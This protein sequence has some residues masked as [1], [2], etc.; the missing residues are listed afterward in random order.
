MREHAKA[1]L[2]PVAILRLFKEGKVQKEDGFIVCAP[3]N[4]HERSVMQVSQHSRNPRQSNS[5]KRA[6]NLT[7]SSD[8]LD[9]AKRL[10][11]NLSKVCD[12]YLREFVRREQERKWRLDHAEF[13][14]AYNASISAEGLPLDQWRGF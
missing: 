2:G 12:D 1:P 10:E 13:V 9:A 4:A 3:T 6:T 11:I 5:G 7:L 8:V 14:E